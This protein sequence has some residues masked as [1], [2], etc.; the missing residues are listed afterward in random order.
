MFE[1][2]LPALAFNENLNPEILDFN[3]YRAHRERVH[4]ATVEVKSLVPKEE[5]R[6]KSSRLNVNGLTLEAISNSPL[7]SER[8]MGDTRQLWILTSGS[9][10]SH[11]KE[12][13]F[14]SDAGQS[15]SYSTGDTRY[16]ATS[17]RSVVRIDLDEKKLIDIYS[18]VVRVKGGDLF[19]DKSRSTPM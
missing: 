2:Q 17:Y 14:P 6:A 12:N 11:S 18:S 10:V 4:G 7:Q 16:F 3:A 13:L 19:L 1:R 8:V 9:A 5:F 15:A